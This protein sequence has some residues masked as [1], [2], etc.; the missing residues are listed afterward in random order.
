MAQIS[1]DRRCNFRNP[2]LFSSVF[3]R[4]IRGMRSKEI[5]IEIELP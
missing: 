3:I 2:F 4:G 5:G 1:T